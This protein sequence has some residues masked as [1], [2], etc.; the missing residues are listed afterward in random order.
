MGA[1]VNFDRAGS[2]FLVELVGV[3]IRRGRKSGIL[4]MK[5]A[6]DFHFSISLQV[7]GRERCGG[8]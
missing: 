8:C 1:E 6:E 4:G 2:L 3:K 5:D 7:K